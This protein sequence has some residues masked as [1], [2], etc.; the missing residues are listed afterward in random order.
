M[1]FRCYVRLYLNCKIYSSSW[2][3]LLH[4]KTEAWMGA[5]MFLLGLLVFGISKLRLYIYN[6]IIWFKNKPNIY[7]FS[8]AVAEQATQHYEQV[9]YHPYSSCQDPQPEVIYIPPEGHIKYIP[10]Y[11]ILHRCRN[12]TGCCW[13]KSQTCTVKTLQIVTR[14]FFVSA[15]FT[16]VSLI[17]QWLVILLYILDTL[18]DNM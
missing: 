11:T 10:E 14:T 12:T 6:Y 9:L 4:F 2:N 17:M 7:P 3:F 8:F 13:D 15:R 18:L 5:A 16:Y 1:F